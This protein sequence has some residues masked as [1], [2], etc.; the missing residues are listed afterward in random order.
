MTYRS[1]FFMFK[2]KKELKILIVE[3]D[4]LLSNILSKEF[5]KNDFAT[6]VIRKGA[7]V[8]EAAKQFIPDMI[9]LD[10]ILPELDGFGVLKQLKEDQKTK[11]IPVVMMSNLDNEGDI[12]SATVL[13][14]EN[15]FIKANVRMEELVKYA[16]KRISK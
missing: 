5:V 10:I 15:Y 8:L 2:K 1:I 9:Y 7:E 12:K 4:A 3:D 16:Q 13:G 6:L 11:N 14:A